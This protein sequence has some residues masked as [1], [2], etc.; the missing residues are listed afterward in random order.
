MANERSKKFLGG[1][2]I[3][4]YRRAEIYVFVYYVMRYFHAVIQSTRNGEDIPVFPPVLVFYFQNRLTN[5]INICWQVCTKMHGTH[6][7]FVLFCSLR[8]V[9]QGGSAIYLFVRFLEN[10]CSYKTDLIEVK[11]CTH[12]QLRLNALY[13]NYF[14]IFYIFTKY[15]AIKAVQKSYF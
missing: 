6:L 11:Y 1:W 14:P 2:A 7:V 9:L 4:A 12:I 13:L 3:C 10:C 5:P 8:S 15:K